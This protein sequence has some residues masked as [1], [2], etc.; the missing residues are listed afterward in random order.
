L[1]HILSIDCHLKQV[2][3]QQ[4]FK[5]KEK[6]LIVEDEKDTR[7]GLCELLEA[8]G[9]DCLG[10]GDGNVALGEL[11]KGKLNLIITDLKMPGMD[12]IE[13]L[14]H[15]R[16][17]NSTLPI[18]IITAYPSLESTIQALKEGAYDYITKPFNIE[19]IRL[20]VKRCLE[21]ESLIAAKEQLL[22]DLQMANEEL[23]KVNEEL[24][25]EKNLK[26]SALYETSKTIEA[27]FELNL[28]LELIVKMI[29][30]IMKVKICSLMLID[31]KQGDLIIRAA[32]GLQDNV[33]KETRIK[34]GEGIS[35]WVA[36]TGE[37]LLIEDI[38]QNLRFKK[39]SEERYITK[40]IL[41]VP[42]KIKGKTTG[43]INV[44]NKISGEVFNEDDQ[45]MLL[46]LSTQISVVIEN[47]YLYNKLDQAHEELK[48]TQEELVRSE[49]LATA[50][51]LA[52][53]VAHEIRNPLSIIG[54]SIQH[55]QDKLTSEDPYRE[56]TN[57]VMNNVQR[58]DKISKRL[59]EFARPH[60]LHLSSYDINKI[61]TQTLNLMKRKCISQKV[62][63]IKNYQ[64]NL[65]LVSI[66]EEHMEEVFLN[67]I[68][69]ALYAMQGGG[70][71]KVR[72][73]LEPEENEVKIAL[74]DTGPGILAENL[75]KIFNPFFTTRADGTGLGLSIVQRI[76]NEHG[77][78]IS[79]QS[80][81]GTTFT[82]SLPLASR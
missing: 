7:E 4:G 19:E 9:Y 20:T 3:N 16:R 56:L 78:S 66:D 36:Q 37:P 17:I 41:S 2:M 38:E 58:L 72:T 61:L 79:V 54:M 49:K 6:I 5:M 52:A 14:H 74:A 25:E 26:I 46:A 8:E 80:Q 24:I 71:L 13:L 69:N 64:H 31:E 18:I 63:I 44:N 23:K 15:I 39:K 40:S 62:K 42:M 29:T 70:V 57:V 53:A 73:W 51:E 77:G 68:N 45:N 60:P 34:I 22:G 27:I 30:R 12:G 55:L 10:T 76:I 59:I 11:K 33:I 32:Q 21:R 75:D 43:V 35:G 50:G 81:S 1:L 65:P 28:L 48:K 82:I 47:A 67:I